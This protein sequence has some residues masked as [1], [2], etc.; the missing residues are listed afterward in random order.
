[1]KKLIYISLSSE[2]VIKNSFHA[3]IIEM[4]KNDFSEVIIFCWGKKYSKKENNL[5]IHSGNIIDWFKYVTKNNRPDLIYINDYFLGG[6]FGTILKKRMQVP[7]FLRCGSP[8][9]YNF[10]SLSAISKTVL[11]HF[12]KPFVIRNCNKVVY[13]SKSIVCKNI[14]HD[15]EIIYNGVDTDIFKPMPEVQTKS[16]KLRLISIGNLNKEKG[17]EYLF[18][19]INGLEDKV[20]LTVVG[21]GPLLQEFK[22]KNKNVEFIGRI[23]HKD[24]PKIINQHDVLVHPSYVESFPN[25]ILE[26]MACGKPV[27]ACNIYGIP[28]MITSPNNGLL[29]SPKNSNQLTKVIIKLVEDHK[30]REK[31]GIEGQKMILTNFKM[32]TKLEKN[33][34]SIISSISKAQF[35]K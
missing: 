2:N 26:A 20:S 6:L 17:L 11:I 18:K 21:D 8:W 23:E 12:L 32:T 1:M 28:E 14:K 22:R 19:A 24:L 7:L 13:N 16:N 35:K 9:R 25:V 5:I 34:Q 29:I 3:D 4:L 10:K 30:I 31:I 27:I 15:Y 33:I